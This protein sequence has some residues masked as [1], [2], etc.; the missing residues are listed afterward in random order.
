MELKTLKDID[1]GLNCKDPKREL[2]AEAAKWVKSIK[3]YHGGGM[4]IFEDY[5]DKDM[6]LEDWIMNFFNLTEEDL[7]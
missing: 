3:L 7:K 5:N 2:K 4:Y 6:D 1:L